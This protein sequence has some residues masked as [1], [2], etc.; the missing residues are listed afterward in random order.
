MVDGGHDQSQVEEAR[1][2]VRRGH[3]YGQMFATWG[4]VTKA[5]SDLGTVDVR[6]GGGLYRNN[7]PVISREWAGTKD[8]SNAV[9]ERD[10]PPVGALVFIVFTDPGLSEALV[11]GSALVPFSETM[12][13]AQ[14]Q[15]LLVSGKEREHKRIREKNWEETY[16]KDTGEY[17]L[18]IAGADFHIKADG[19]IDVTGVAGKKITMIVNGATIEIADDGAINVIS[20]TGKNA[21]VNAGSGGKVMLGGGG[22][23]VNN[24]TNCLMMGIAHSLQTKVECPVMVLP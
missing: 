3:L 2:A 15:N 11:I 5:N 18:Q 12:G 6:F 9:G 20:A 8:G 7:V 13:D 16:D 1:I 10:L 14:K 22:S 4:I 17:E 21:N 23:P 24:C 19:E